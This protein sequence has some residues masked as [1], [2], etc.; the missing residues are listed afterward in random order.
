MAC[1][2]PALSL[3]AEMVSSLGTLQGLVHTERQQ[4]RRGGKLMD[5]DKAI[6]TQVCAKIAADMTDKTKAV[7]ERIGEFATLF[8]SIT[9]ML[10]EEIY[11][12]NTLQES[13]AR[14]VSMVQQT[15]NAEEVTKPS[16]TSTG[17]V[18]IAGQQHGEIPDWLIKAC[19]RDG[20]TK[21]YD[22]RDGLAQN[23]KRPWFKA[24]DDKEKA[25]WPPRGK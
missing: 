2:R 19:K 25:Y 17:A 1:E 14:I 8:S 4:Q 16:I 11:G 24:V 12:G 5:K 6:I 21:V 20:V 18:Q 9:E 22:N 15:F 23:P 13:N 3:F 10:M 7:D